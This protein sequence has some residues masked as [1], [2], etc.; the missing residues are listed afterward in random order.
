LS[1][2]SSI[3]RSLRRLKPESFV[4][5]LKPRTRDELN[6]AGSPKRP[7]PK[8]LLDT[9]V[10]IDELQGVLPRE[11]EMWLQVCEVWHSS[12]TEAELTALIGL[13]NPKHGK[14]ADAV[15]QIAASVER[16]PEHRIMDPDRQVWAE[17]GILAGLLSRLQQYGHADR[18]RALND[19]LIY[20]SAAKHGCSVLTRNVIDFDFLQQIFPGGR[21]V[22]YERIFPKRD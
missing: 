2:S 11:V 12:V 22:F 20:L 7:F 14:T 1:S 18:R 9:T 6:Y 3:Q 13:L 8:L 16:R 15:A 4:V 19:A 21:V 10:Y 17:A 5:Q